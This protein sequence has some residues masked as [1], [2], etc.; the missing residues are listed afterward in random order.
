M[1]EG[2]G[3]GDDQAPQAHASSRARYSLALQRGLAILG[4]FSAEQPRFGVAEIAAR[5]GMSRATT[6]RYLSTLAE[7]GYLRQDDSRKYSLRL[8]V[9]DLGLAALNATE[10]P[11]HAHPYMAALASH[12]RHPVELAVLDGC[13][14]LIV[15]SVGKTAHRR[16]EARVGERRPAHRT[17][18]GRVM[19]AHLRQQTRAR[20]LHQ[21]EERERAEGVN[22]DVQELCRD[23]DVIHADGLAALDEE[24]ARDAFTVAAPVRGESGEVLAALGIAVGAELIEVEELTG[25]FGSQ[26]LRAAKEISERL[27]WG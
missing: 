8:S 3:D 27:G 21:L 16:H 14:S 25:R 5:L 4:C 22:L 26:L 2:E 23:L 1:A 12:V 20:L 19:I 11:T 15:H 7:L 17:S 18:A 13:E 9:A 10:L 24:R 6:H